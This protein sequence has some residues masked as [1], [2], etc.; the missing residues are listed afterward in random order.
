MQ[1]LILLPNRNRLALGNFGI[2]TDA[3]RLIAGLI[4]AAA[5]LYQQFPGHKI[6]WAPVSVA[7]LVTLFF[8][9]PAR[10]IIN[11]SA[12]VYA[13]SDGKVL[14]VEKLRDAQFGDQEWLRIIVFLSVLDVHINRAP[15]AGKVI[16]IIQERGRF[17]YAKAQAAEHNMAQYT[18]IEGVHGRCIVAQRTGFLARRIVNRNKLHY[19][20]AQGEKFGLIRFGSRTDV[21][22][23]A[24]KIQALV[25]KGD[26]V[27]AGETVIAQYIKCF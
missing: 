5:L 1:N 24:N 9:D 15:I 2:D 16:D 25:K 6:W 20:L 8:R 10:R 18:V 21:Y 26:S 19:C 4:V 12:A 7:L 13:A 11:N 22:L 27:K 3:L 17:A 23:P 14:A